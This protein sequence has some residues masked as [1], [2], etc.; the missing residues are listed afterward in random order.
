MLITT[1]DQVREV[2]GTAIRKENT[3]DV[4]RPYL[5]QVEEG[6]V[7]GLIGQAQLTALEAIDSAQAD[8]KPAR[9]LKLVQRAIVWNGYL[10]AWYHTM[11]ELSGTGL[12]RQKPKDTELLFRYQEDNIR[13]DIVRK[14]DQAIEE[15]MDF[16]GAN[17]ADFSAWKE[18][19]EYKSNFSF[20]IT[21]ATALHESL[22]E[23]SQSY[24][25]YMVLRAYMPRVERATV[26]VI[27]GAA[28]F[29]SLKAKLKA[30]GFDSAQP[31]NELYAQLLQL[32]SNYL[33][34]ATLLEAMPFIRV[35]FS[36][37]GVRIL[38]TM[39]NLHDEVA[40]QDDQSSYLMGVLRDRAN[41][42]KA[43]LRKF[44]NDR[45]SATVFPDYF[46]SGLY[47]APGSRVWR[48]PDNDDKRHFRL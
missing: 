33:A 36:T 8:N 10:E 17:S 32:A 12:N 43:Q 21:S 22:P 35:Q 15:M 41:D 13:K 39:N 18:S 45:A 4:L 2:V 23:V 38:S 9:L 37:S 44:L 40:I 5:L 20:L 25:M 34:P 27:L 31:D 11:Y 28:L 26:R 6:L 7:A 42:A 1:I 19:A 47:V 14:S 48:L 46:T 16:L 3:F 29:D 30:G 24:R